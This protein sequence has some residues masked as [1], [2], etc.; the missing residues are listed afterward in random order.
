MSELR[1][2]EP[3]FAGAVFRPSDDSLGLEDASL[4]LEGGSLGLDA[5][6][7]WCGTRDDSGGR[8][9]RGTTGGAGDRSAATTGVPS[10]A[11]IAA[12]TAPLIVLLSDN[13]APGSSTKKPAP[14]NRLRAGPRGGPH[15][16]ANLQPSSH[17]PLA[18]TIDPRVSEL[19][20]QQPASLPV[21][22]RLLRGVGSVDK[23]RLAAKGNIPQNPHR[24]S[25]EP[26]SRE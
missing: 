11:I 17:A 8:R 5:L 16:C 9:W 24:P 1:G 6:G 4:G 26:G 3:G 25:L 18:P 13:L 21:H 14:G 20:S 15:R 12:T 23:R 19:R 7:L 22:P 2:G 10:A